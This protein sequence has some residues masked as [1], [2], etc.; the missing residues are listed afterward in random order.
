MI[1]PRGARGCLGDLVG[2]YVEAALPAQEKLAWDRHLVACI[3]CRGAVDLERRLKD[4]LRAAPRVPDDL[5]GLLLS[6]SQEIPVAVPATSVP[7]APARPGPDLGV[8]V[9]APGAPAQ[10]R[11]MLRA[12]VFAT[13]AAS[14]SVVAVWGIA[15]APATGPIR[16]GPGAV[17]PRPVNEGV[18][19]TRLQLGVVG[20]PVLSREALPGAQSTP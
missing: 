15:M 3:G 2:D 14:A 5:R 9:L 7:D 4:T 6:V 1:R 20:E 16:T 19:P 10:H 18:A 11:S 12:A 8:A 13:A 17:T